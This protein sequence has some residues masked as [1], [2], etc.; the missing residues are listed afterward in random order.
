MNPGSFA[1]CGE[2]DPSGEGAPTCFVNG[3]PGLVEVNGL[4]L[5]MRCPS[6]LVSQVSQYAFSEGFWHGPWKTGVF[7]QVSRGRATSYMRP[8]W[9]VGLVIAYIDGRVENQ[10]LA[11]P[12]LLHPP[13]ATKPHHGALVKP[14]RQHESSISPRHQGPTRPPVQQTSHTSKLAPR[15]RRSSIN[16]VTLIYTN[17]RTPRLTPI[18]LLQTPQLRRYTHL[19]RKQ[20]LRAVDISTI[21]RTCEKRTRPPRPSAPSSRPPPRVQKN[22]KVRSR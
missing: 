17:M 4:V 21:Q 10:H 20:I 9:C 16:K 13:E 19:A 6:V 7:L 11:L 5:Y 3:L 1:C 2:G 14:R 8:F 12:A 22:A 18:P 15:S